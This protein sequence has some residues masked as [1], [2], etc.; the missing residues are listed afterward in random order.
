[1]GTAFFRTI[2]LN[3]MS[4][5]PTQKN[6]CP[7]LSLYED[8][9]GQVFEQR[10]N[11][12]IRNQ[13]LTESLKEDYVSDIVSISVNGCRSPDEFRKMLTSIMDSS[14]IAVHEFLRNIDNCYWQP[15][16][17]YLRKKISELKDIVGD[18]SITF[19]DAFGKCTG[20]HHIKSFTEFR[21]EGFKEGYFMKCS[22]ELLLQIE[23]FAKVWL[24]VISDTLIRID[25]IY[26]LLQQSLKKDKMGSDP[27]SGPLKKF[28]LTVAQIG[29]LLNLL[30]EKKIL[31]IPP[32]RKTEFLNWFIE[33]FH[34][35][36][37]DKLQVASL[38][39]KFS[40]PEL[41]AIDFWEVKGK[42]FQ[43]KIQEDRDRLTK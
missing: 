35:K 14:L 32:G 23:K 36:N 17:D 30:V 37:K 16:L 11:F 33:N 39:N 8:F 12:I 7:S 40:T 42:E 3:F 1:L 19:T 20:N 9:F 38:R 18:E 29:Y 22:Q 21:L 26:D 43:L 24:E 6:Q 34:S 31:V 25:M 41:S 4:R 10:R 13:L 2:L 15:Q 28:N 5:K 27:E